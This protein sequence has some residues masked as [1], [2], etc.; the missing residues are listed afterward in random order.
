M[1]EK[2]VYKIYNNVDGD[3]MYLKRD[4]EEK[5]I[6]ASRNFVSLLGNCNIRLKC[7]T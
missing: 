4:I 3:I 6:E 7:L 5:I 1:V 2:I